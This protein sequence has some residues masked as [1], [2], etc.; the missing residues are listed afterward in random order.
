MKNL[1]NMKDK[2]S[3]SVNKTDNWNVVQAPTTKAWLLSETLAKIM[4][5]KQKRIRLI[6]YI[7]ISVLRNKIKIK[8]KEN[9]L[10]NVLIVLKKDGDHLILNL[11]KWCP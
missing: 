3:I 9:L 10:R 11:I 7:V 1:V 8:T 4:D 5:M 6:G 2:S